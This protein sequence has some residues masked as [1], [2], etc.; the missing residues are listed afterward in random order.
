MSH[1]REWALK[2]AMTMMVVY[3][4]RSQSGGLLGPDKDTYVEL[5]RLLRDEIEDNGEEWPPACYFP[6][7]DGR[8]IEDISVEERIAFNTEF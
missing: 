1:K 3:G 5:S 4:R 6:C 7:P 2:Q 8:K